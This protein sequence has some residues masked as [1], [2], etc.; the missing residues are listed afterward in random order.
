MVEY[1]AKKELP[2]TLTALLTLTLNFD[3]NK[4]L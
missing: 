2:I 3:K 1:K 4:K